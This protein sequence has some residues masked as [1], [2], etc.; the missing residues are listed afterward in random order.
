MNSRTAVSV[1]VTTGTATFVMLTL[2]PGVIHGLRAR[3]YKS[4]EELCMGQAIMWADMASAAGDAYN[5]TRMVV[6]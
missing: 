6:L 1:L 3:L 5:R 4:S 2:R